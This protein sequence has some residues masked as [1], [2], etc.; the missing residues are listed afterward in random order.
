[1]YNLEQHL[2]QLRTKHFLEVSD[3]L[4]IAESEFVTALC[5][6][7]GEI[8]LDPLYFGDLDALLQQTLGVGS[9]I[10]LQCLGVLCFNEHVAFFCH[11]LCELG[12]ESLHELGVCRSRLDAVRS[13]LVR[14]QVHDFRLYGVDTLLGVQLQFCTRFLVQVSRLALGSR[15]ERSCFFLSFSNDV[16]SLGVRFFY[17]LLCFGIAFLYAFRV[18]LVG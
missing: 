14:Q 12:D 5:R 6:L 3:E 2:N 8:G 9:K 17:D 16:S 13:D 7:D 15:N 1:M 11:L 18:D 10:F 4:G